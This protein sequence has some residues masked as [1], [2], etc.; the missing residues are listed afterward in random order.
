MG[1]AAGRA[2]RAPLSRDAEIHNQSIRLILTPSYPEDFGL[3][4]LC[5]AGGAGVARH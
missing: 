3:D 1:A 5:G 2:G 4:V